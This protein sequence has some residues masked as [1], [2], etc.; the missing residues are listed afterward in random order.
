W[1][2]LCTDGF[3]VSS[4]FEQTNLVG[5]G[6]SMGQNC[7]QRV[8]SSGNTSQICTRVFDDE[9][10]RFANKNTTKKVTD[11]QYQIYEQTESATD[12]VNDSGSGNRDGFLRSNLQTDE[13]RDGSGRSSGSGSG[14][15]SGRSATQIT[16]T[17]TATTAQPSHRI[18]R[19][20]TY[21]HPNLIPTHCTLCPIAVS[22]LAHPRPVV[23][24]ASRR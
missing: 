12:L 18:L 23:K 21:R 16:P 1:T 11:L 2:D 5:F 15:G 13:V 4:K 7:A 10:E 6:E 19:P 3:A 24:A 20:T 8:G 22:A 9:S 14:G 17:T